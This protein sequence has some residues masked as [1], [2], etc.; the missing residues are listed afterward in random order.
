MAEGGDARTQYV[1]F[2]GAP[3]ANRPMILRTLGAQLRARIWRAYVR[4][5]EATA[6]LRRR[7]Q[8]GRRSHGHIFARN[9]QL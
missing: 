6:S 3:D 2:A 7:L 8:P 9:G 4:A 5:G 1:Q